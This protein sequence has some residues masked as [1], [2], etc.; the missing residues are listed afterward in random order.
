V[1]NSVVHLP[2]AAIWISVVKTGCSLDIQVGGW[3]TLDGIVNQASPAVTAIIGVQPF[4]DISFKPDSV[5]D[6]TCLLVMDLGEY[7]ISRDKIHG[8][9][10]SILLPC[11]AHSTSEATSGA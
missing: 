5:R 10:L 4:G 9:P 7:P 8:I 11:A 3:H 1:K 6:V 2:G